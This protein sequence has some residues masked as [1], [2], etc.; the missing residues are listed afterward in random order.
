MN[1]PVKRMQ[2]ILTSKAKTNIITLVGAAFLIGVG[3]VVGG[4]VVLVGLADLVPAVHDEGA[5]LHHGLTDGA[6]L[7]EQH[8]T[9]LG[10]GDQRH[11]EMGVERRAVIRPY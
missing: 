7:E 2:V 4:L 6:T 3:L 1:S 9:R 8:P 5:V 11:G 10:T